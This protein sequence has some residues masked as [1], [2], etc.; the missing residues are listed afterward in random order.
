MANAILRL[1]H[2]TKGY[3]VVISV[4]IP[5]FETRKG[6][7]VIHVDIAIARDGG[8]Y[9]STQVVIEFA[10]ADLQDGLLAS[11]SPKVS[12]DLVEGCGG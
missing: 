2:F 4:F 12:P 8:I 10:K 3:R 6:L 5:A 9:I 11:H 7:Y 1:Q